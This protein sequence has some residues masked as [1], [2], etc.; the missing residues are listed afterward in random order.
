MQQTH[1]RVDLPLNGVHSNDAFLSTNNDLQ[2]NPKELR[3]YTVI[4]Q[5]QDEAGYTATDILKILPEKMPLPEVEK[6]LMHFIEEG[7]IFSTIDE[8]HFKVTDFGG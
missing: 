6:I 4:K 8:N 1:N 2:L 3:V 5:C 7:H